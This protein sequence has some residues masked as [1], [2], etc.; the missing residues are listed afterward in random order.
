MPRGSA[1][2]AIC[3][4]LWW[5]AP[6]ARRQDDKQNCSEFHKTFLPWDHLRLGG[7]KGVHILVLVTFQQD[8][9]G[10]WATIYPP[11]AD[12]KTW[13]LS[14]L[15]ERFTY[16]NSHWEPNVSGSQEEVKKGLFLEG[17]WGPLPPVS[18]LLAPSTVTSSFT[19]S[20]NSAL[21]PGDYS[22]GRLRRSFSYSY[23][24]LPPVY[25]VV[26]PFLDLSQAVFEEEWTL[27]VLVEATLPAPFTGPSPIFLLMLCRDS[28]RVSMKVPTHSLLKN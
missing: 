10:V 4:P 24:F 8:T 9:G 25:M 18:L 5:L 3:A 15:S 21:K 11:F 2:L 17:A 20:T 27:L 13:T 26:F 1:G 22:S 28:S 19:S 23:P 12:P 7:P 16:L 6:D 14:G